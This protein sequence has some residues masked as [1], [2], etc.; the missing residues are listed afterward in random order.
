MSL[1]RSSKEGITYCYK[2]AAPPELKG[3]NNILLQECRSSGAQIQYP[4]NSTRMSLL[5]SSKEGITYCYK[6]AAPP[7]LMG[8]N[9]IFLQECRS[10][11]AQRQEPIM[12]Q[13]YRS[14][15]AYSNSKQL[16]IY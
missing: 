11:E 5:R 7:E 13:E 10:S 16:V 3:R 14:I 9:N 2:N 4:Y 12:L 8:R 6:N 1:L 15:S